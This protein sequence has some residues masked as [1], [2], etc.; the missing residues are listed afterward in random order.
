MKVKL[1]NGSEK[2]RERKRAVKKV[3]LLNNV[4]E[5]SFSMD[6][7]DVQALL[8]GNREGLGKEKQLWD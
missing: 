4:G 2:M 7:R 3:T 8:A 6:D 5:E 1:R